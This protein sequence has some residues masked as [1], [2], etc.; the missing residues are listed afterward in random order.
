MAEPSD[1]LDCDEV[2]R[3]RA[4]VSKRIEGRDPRAEQWRRVRRVER[5]RHPR[6]GFD[7]HN[8][9]L[10]I[11]TVVTESCDLHVGAVDEVAT[12]ARE[13]G[14]VL[15]AVPAHADSLTFLPLRHACARFVDHPGD[16]VPWHARVHEAWPAAFLGEDI[17]VADSARLHANSH[18]PRRWLRDV[19]LDD[20]EVRACLRD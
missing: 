9:V 16:F 6:D 17:A 4:A 7:R 8:H 19:P 2:A 12:P 18:L 20:L 11:A 10:R 3:H 5:L 1:S 15:T 14:P 13:A